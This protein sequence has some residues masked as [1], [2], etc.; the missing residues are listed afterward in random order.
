MDPLEDVLSL[1]DT[2]SYL[3]DGLI[4]GGTW[5][6][7]F[8][9]P[10]AGVKFNAVRRG[11][12]LLEVEGLDAPVELAEGDCY[13]L[14][15]PRKFRLLSDP[16]AV[17]KPAHPLFAAAADGWARTGTGD[18][19]EL[20]GGG[21][22]FGT[23]ART[24]LLDNLPP[25]VHV[26]AA[27]PQAATVRWAVDRIDTERRTHRLAAGLVTEHLAVIMLIEILRLHLDR[28]PAS[29]TGWLAGLTDPVVAS[30]LREIHTH[31]E[32]PWTVATLAGAA[33]VS[34][35]T[36][37]ARFRT[38]V[39]RGPLDYLTTW[40]IELAANRLRRTDAPVAVIARDVGYGSES[41]LN[42]AFKRTMNLT[43]AAYR[44]AN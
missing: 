14:T 44:R 30:A 34:R 16:A 22:S 32:R 33:A 25:V 9:P 28:D 5:A 36:L 18:D 3:S 42:V 6:V 40:R 7:D 41:A 29:V 23:R 21:F 11:H 19:V 15:R 20:I 17:P 27:T 12:C 31:P 37:A 24:L 38:A 1:L 8:E 35:S 4:A 2:R 10:G 26:P 13:L 39:G 43:P